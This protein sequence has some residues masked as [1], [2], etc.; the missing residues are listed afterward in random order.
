MIIYGLPE[1]TGSTPAECRSND[2]V[3]FSSLV[4]SEFNIHTVEISESFRLGK[5]A[6]GK[7]RPLLITVMDD[8]VR[9]QI[10]KNLCKSS[11]YQNVFILLDLSPKERASNKT[12]HQE[13]RRRKLKEAS[14]TNLIIR[15]GKI[16]TKQIP[17][18]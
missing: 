17:L 7:R 11:T 8:H 13:L 14:E 1:P 5:C 10:L 9:S 6:E 2:D 4:N 12:L 3:Y 16:V 18:L 15:H